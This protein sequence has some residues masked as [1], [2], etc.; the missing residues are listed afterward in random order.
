MKMP[1]YILGSQNSGAQGYC[2]ERLKSSL[3][4]FRRLSFEQ[5]VIMVFVS[6]LQGSLH[7]NQLSEDIRSISSLTSFRHA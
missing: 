4:L 6:K 3:L 5:N 2:L 1:I 7:Y